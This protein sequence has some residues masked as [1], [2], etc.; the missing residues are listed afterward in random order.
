MS[1]MPTWHIAE[2]WTRAHRG[3]QRERIKTEVSER[4]G[5]TQAYLKP[6]TLWSVN[7]AG[8]VPVG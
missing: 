6:H 5:Q 2:D 1:Y 3:A 8:S 4:L 7:V